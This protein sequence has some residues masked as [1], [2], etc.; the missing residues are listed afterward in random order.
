[1]KLRLKEGRLKEELVNFGE[2]EFDCGAWDDETDDEPYEHYYDK[3]KAAEQSLLQVIREL[4]FD[5]L[6]AHSITP[7]TSKKADEVLGLEVV[8]EP[9]GPRP[10]TDTMSGGKAT[11]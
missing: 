10:W 7:A 6:E 11:S 2:A 9:D 8:E 3:A 1:M 4:V 5:V